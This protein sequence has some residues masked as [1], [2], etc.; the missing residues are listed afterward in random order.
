MHSRKCGV[1]IIHYDATT[2]NLSS[3]AGVSYGYQDSSHF[4]TVTYLDSVQ[5]YWYR[6]NENITD[7]IVGSDSYDLA[8]DANNRLVT[9]EKNQTMVGEYVYD[10][11]GSRVKSV[12]G[13]VTTY[14]I[15]NYY[16][17]RVETSSST[18]VNY[19]YAGSQRVTMR[20]GTT[21]SYLFGDHLAPFG[22]ASRAAPRSRRTRAGV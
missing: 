15:G 16:E 2:G 6:C 20:V 19:Y 18:G 12:A 8:Y 1:P 14:Y 21:L 3:K 22:C 7:R 11:D 9:V 17:W 10:G 4:H 13:G 5:K